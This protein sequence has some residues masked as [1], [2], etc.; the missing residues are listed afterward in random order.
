[1]AADDDTTRFE[2][3]DRVPDIH[4]HTHTHFHL[5]IL[6]FSDSCISRIVFV[7]TGNCPKFSNLYA[8]MRLAKNL[9]GRVGVKENF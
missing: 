1:M 5:Y 2:D 3:W 7:E 6:D 4:T 8:Y 9:G